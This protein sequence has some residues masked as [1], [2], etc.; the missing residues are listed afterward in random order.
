MPSQVV[1]SL[2][3]KTGVSTTNAE[4]AWAKIKKAVVGAKLRSG[5]TIPANSDKWTDEMWAY[6]MGSFKRAIRGM[7]EDLIEQVMK[8]ANA[9]AVLDTLI[10]SKG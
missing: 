3:K 5:A 2:A 8:G 9:S 7:G 4:D 6:V 1:A 10:E